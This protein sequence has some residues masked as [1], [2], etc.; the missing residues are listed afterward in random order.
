MKLY[1]LVLDDPPTPP[2][3]DHYRSGGANRLLVEVDGDE[4][5]PI[6][7]AIG[8]VQI[9]GGNVV[10]VQPPDADTRA[11]GFARAF[12]AQLERQRALRRQRGEDPG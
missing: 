3:L 6:Q 11:A 2:M 12:T 7:Q 8:V 9:H 10:E 4:V 1:G 5:G